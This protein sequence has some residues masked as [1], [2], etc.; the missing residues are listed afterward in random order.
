MIFISSTNST[1]GCD[2]GPAEQRYFP[3]HHHL[4][5]PSVWCVIMRIGADDNFTKL[6]LPYTRVCIVN[7]PR[8]WLLV[9]AGRIHGVY[10]QSGALNCID[11]S[12]LCRTIIQSIP[13]M[14]LDSLIIE[15]WTKQW[16]VVD[17]TCWI[18]APLTMATNNY[19]QFW[20]FIF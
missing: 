2:S 14:Y 5:F 15:L 10:F 20:L 8:C 16:G 12:Q 13:I 11:L 4:M 6:K 17:C 3:P 9:A 1:R 7:R 18:R 19:L